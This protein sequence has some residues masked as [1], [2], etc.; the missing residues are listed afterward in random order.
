MTRARRLGLSA[1][2]IGAAAL[3]APSLPSAGPTLCPFALATGVA[4]PLCGLTRST[5]LLLQGDLE[6]SLVLH[7]LTFPVLAAVVATWAWWGGSERGRSNAV[8]AAAIAAALT[9]VWIARWATG[10]LPPV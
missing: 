10:D 5:I 4:C 7:P 1:A 3:L 6:A 2:T 9:V 8:R